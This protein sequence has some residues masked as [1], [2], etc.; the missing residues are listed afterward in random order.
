MTNLVRE[1]RLTTLIREVLG[2]ATVAVE[3][4]LAEDADPAGKSRYMNH[5]V[6]L[7]RVLSCTPDRPD[8]IDKYN[9]LKDDCCGWAP[10]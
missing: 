4:S 8:V 5:N 9:W 1:H 6:T 2:V 7:H 3:V 10:L